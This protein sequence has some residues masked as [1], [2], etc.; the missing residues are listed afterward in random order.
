MSASTQ[1]DPF[2]PVAKSAHAVIEINIA[3]RRNG[4]L[5]FLILGDDE[6][7]APSL[8]ATSFLRNHQFS[9][10]KPPSLVRI[11][12]AIG[13]LHD[14]HVL[15]ND[16]RTMTELEL[17]G[18]LKRFFEA[19]RYGNAK[20][21]WKPVDLKSAQDDVRWVSEYSSYCATNFG[22]IPL[23]PREQKLLTSMTGKEFQAWLV[24]AKQRRD[25][26][27]MFHTYRASKEGRGQ[28]NHRGFRPEAGD[29]VRAE[30]A[31]YFPPEHVL[32][33]IAAARSLRD[34]LSWMLIFF[35]GL[36]ISELMHIFTR[37]ITR[38]RA[39]GEAT[40]VLAH[41][42]EA[43]TDWVTIAGKNRTGTRAAFLAEKYDLTP[44]NQ[45]GAKDP[46]YA[47]WKGMMLDEP[48]SKQSTV[49]W[50]V[51]GAGQ[52]FWEMHAEYMR[53]ERLLAPDNHPYYFISLYDD[54]HGQPLKLSNLHKQFER[55]AARIGLNTSTLGV[56]PHGGRHFYGYYLATVL[57][58]P[59]DRA[60]KALHHRN[61]SSTSVYYHLT[62]EK[63]RKEMVEAYSRVRDEL[64]AFLQAPQI[65]L[66]SGNEDE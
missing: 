11:A 18:F 5:P 37:D 2:H 50:L 34:R 14:F 6:D 54:A 4:A 44:R 41:P 51:P 52:L 59:I 1:K 15:A 57:G 24:S 62:K 64:P 16:A 27:M 36:R 21:G 48:K 45:L 30:T 23:N 55:C 49:N 13:L 9:G 38:D 17:Q 65:L 46:Y 43:N 63:M 26:D 53:T 31:E 60:Q 47:G 33:F 25:N 12:R 10:T 56:N 22:H 3:E 8:L 40:V 42:V 39:T 58:L 32:D 28:T 19:R 20:L 29:A 35:G 61:I 7:A 66:T